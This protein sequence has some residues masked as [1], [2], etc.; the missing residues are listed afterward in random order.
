M[1]NIHCLYIADED[2]DSVKCTCDEADADRRDEADDSLDELLLHH[3]QT[4]I[5]FI[6]LTSLLHI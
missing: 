1:F 2:A 6:C 5:I 3:I 4:I